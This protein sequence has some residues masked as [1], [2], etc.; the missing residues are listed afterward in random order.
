LTVFFGISLTLEIG[1]TLKPEFGRKD[2]IWRSFRQ[3]KAVL[4]WGVAE[5]L[6][7]KAG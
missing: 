7:S 3:K 2:R 6:D 1:D 5:G 4:G